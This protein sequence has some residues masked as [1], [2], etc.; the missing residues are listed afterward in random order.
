M[1]SFKSVFDFQ[2]YSTSVIRNSRY[3]WSSEIKKFLD[4]VLE[5]GKEKSRQI[6]HNTIL[7]RAQLGHDWQPFKFGDSNKVHQMPSPYSFSRMKPQLDRAKEGRANPKG[8]SYLYTSN[9]KDTAM[10]EVR[11]GLASYISLAQLMT[12]RD[13]KIVDF[14]NTEKLSM[15]SYVFEEDP[16]KIDEY[17]L[18]CIGEA[19]SEPVNP[20][21]D[22]AEYVPTQIITELY[23][24]DGFDGLAYN[25]S[26]SKGHNILLFDINCA[27]II[28]CSLCSV[29]NITYEFEPIL[30]IQ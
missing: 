7:W 6:Q 1:S 2:Q 25:S 28:D 29:K 4:L 5:K 13:L 16:K 15:L 19:F 21:D 8:I 11:P 30:D 14:T 24:N 10:S 23:R 17:I 12:Q 18:H 9:N 27:E 22:L 26:F 20:S 3:I